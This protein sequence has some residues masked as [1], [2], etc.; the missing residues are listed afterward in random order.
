[1]A[2]ST[3]LILRGGLGNQLFQFI[4]AESYSSEDLIYIECGFPDE[5]FPREVERDLFLTTSNSILISSNRLKTFTGVFI[6]KCFGVSA[7]NPGSFSFGVIR[8][9]FEIIG[10]IYFSFYYCNFVHLQIAEGV[11]YS[12]IKKSRFNKLLIGYFQSYEYYSNLGIQIPFSEKSHEGRV[13]HYRDLS[14]I[15][16]PL[17]VHQRFGD[18]LGQ[19]LFGI[20]SEKFLEQAIQLIS[21]TREFG[22]I[23]LFS[24]D[25]NLARE[26]IPDDY[27]SKVRE[28]DDVNLS[29]LETLEIMTFGTGFVIANSSF[30]WWSATLANDSSAPVIAPSPWFRGLEEPKLLIPQTW[31]RLEAGYDVQDRI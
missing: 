9:V 3:Y 17:V 19:D 8:K 16:K 13:R 18:Y 31:I 11:G 29:P 1:M 14:V 15:E 7:R 20:P 28:I 27:R 25:L 26:R 23:W 22:A 30:S 2:K 6:D 21:N 5:N 4:A 12:R 24:D 10:S